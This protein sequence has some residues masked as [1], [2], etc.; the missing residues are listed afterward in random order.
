MAGGST[1]GFTEGYKLFVY[2]CTDILAQLGAV[3][4]DL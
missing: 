2:G 1:Y 4:V 3:A